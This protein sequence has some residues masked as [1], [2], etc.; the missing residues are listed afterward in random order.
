MSQLTAATLVAVGP[1]RMHDFHGEFISITE[2][3]GF[4]RPASGS[5]NSAV[6]EQNAAPSVL[7]PHER[8]DTAATIRRFDAAIITHLNIRITP[9]PRSIGKIV[10]VTGAWIPNTWGS[11]TTLAQ[12]AQV[13]GRI[14]ASFG[15]SPNL[16]APINFPL[17]PHMSH[18]LKSPITTDHV[19]FHLYVE[20]T[21]TA[22]SMSISAAEGSWFDIDYT[23]EYDTYGGL[24]PPSQLN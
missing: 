17:P 8:T 24:I 9:G 18:I 4:Y 14:R 10:T 20:S 7:T 16:S 3:H 21:A 1:L 23:C 13:P 19:K 12:M 6:T 5:G 22:G 15:G 11:V 2:D